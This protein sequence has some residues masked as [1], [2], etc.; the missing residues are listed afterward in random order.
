[1]GKGCWALLCCLSHIPARFR[2]G[3]RSGIA[4]R[5]NRELPMF[6]DSGPKRP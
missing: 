3:S 1:M 5:V 6:L 4:R 2:L